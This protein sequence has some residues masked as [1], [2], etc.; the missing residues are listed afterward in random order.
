MSIVC[1]CLAASGL[2]VVVLSLLER[3]AVSF[4]CGGELPVAWFRR[5]SASRNL[6]CK[7]SSS[8]ACVL[9]ACFLEGCQREYSAT[10]GKN[11]LLVD[12]LVQVVEATVEVEQCVELVH[13]VAG[14]G[15]AAVSMGGSYA[16][17]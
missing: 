14:N 6:L 11:S 3:A 13:E 16:S 4:F 10:V 17:G 9:T 5:S 15:A 7:A 2:A 12:G 1:W 8:C